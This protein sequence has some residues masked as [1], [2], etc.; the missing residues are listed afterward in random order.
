[1][2]PHLS[3]LEYFDCVTLNMYGLYHF[4]DY[5]SIKDTEWRIYIHV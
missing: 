5:D 4:Q 1:M 2:F 3:I